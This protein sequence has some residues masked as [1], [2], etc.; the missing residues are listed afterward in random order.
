MQVGEGAITSLNIALTPLLTDADND[1]IGDTPYTVFENV[2]DHYPLMNPFTIEMVRTSEDASQQNSQTSSES[3]N[4]TSPTGPA[5]GNPI[6]TDDENPI[7]PAI[8]SLSV[9][10]IGIGA[11]LYT[12]IFGLFFASLYFI[13]RKQ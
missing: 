1:G 8:G 9:S 12:S 13:R 10:S 3:E 6:S 11:L 7:K 2:V 4:T 5:D